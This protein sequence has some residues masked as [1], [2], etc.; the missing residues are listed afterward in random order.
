MLTD[1]FYSV[2]GPAIIIVLI[3]IVAF[4]WWEGKK[5]DELGKAISLLKISIF[6]TG[7]LSVVLCFLLPSTA[8]LGS[9]GF[10]ETIEEIQSN[11]QLLS[12]LQ[13]YNEAIVRTTKVIYWFIFIFVWGF[14][15]S[16]YSVIKAFSNLKGEEH[17]KNVKEKFSA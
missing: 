13:E 12:Y 3:L 15:T 14:L 10:P 2:F 1:D 5:Q 11:E 7:F 16:L 8:T 17:F 6:T 4:K 9:F